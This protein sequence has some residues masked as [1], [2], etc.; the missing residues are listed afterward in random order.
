MIRLD[1]SKDRFDH[2]NAQVSEPETRLGLM[3]YVKPP[4]YTAVTSSST[5]AVQLLLSCGADP[6]FGF[7]NCPCLEFLPLALAISQSETA[8]VEMFI[9]SGARCDV[10]LKEN[11]TML[12]C[13]ARCRDFRDHEDGV[14]GAA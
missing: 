3:R 9:K 12:H 11:W 1:P 2:R 10:V 5:V 4:L 8:M 6:N 14:E 13:A 7:P